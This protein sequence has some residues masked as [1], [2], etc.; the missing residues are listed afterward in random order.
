MCNEA[1]NGGSRT[2][3]RV[4]IHGYCDGASEIT[5]DCNSRGCNE[6]AATCGSGVQ[7]SLIVADSQLSASSFWDSVN[8]PTDH[9]HRHGRLFGTGGVAAWVAG[10]TAANEWI[11]VDYLNPVQILGVATQGRGD[12]GKW[13]GHDQWVSQY[14]VSYK[15]DENA[16]FQFVVD[17]SGA[18]VVFG[19]NSD[20]ET[21]V[22]NQFPSKVTA[23]IFRINPIV[24]HNYISMRFEFLTC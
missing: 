6:A 9:H 20:K 16:S 15:T 22:A 17:D 21:V 1:C 14:T 18:T 12:G 11:Q 4:C 19:G 24:W 8:N 10:T 3:T 5:V 23:R 7:D 13:P 2:D